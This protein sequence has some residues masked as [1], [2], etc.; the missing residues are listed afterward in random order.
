MKETWARYSTI[1]DRFSDAIDKIPLTA[2]PAPRDI[3]R[4]EEHHYWPLFDDHP[5][6]EAC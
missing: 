6:G 2:S 5:K 4:D 3:E 1:K